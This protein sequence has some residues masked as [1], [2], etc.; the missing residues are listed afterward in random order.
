MIEKL[1]AWS[2]PGDWQRVTTLDVHTEGEPLRIITGGFPALVGKTILQKREFSKKNFDTLR[3]LLM[4]EPRGHA[5]MYGCIVT[6]QV[7][8]DADLGVLFL[9]NEGYSTMCGHGVI[10]LASAL[11]QTGAIAPVEPETKIVMDTPAGKVTAFVRVQGG[12]VAS[13]YFHNVPS[14]VDSLDRTLDVPEFGK[15]HYDIAFGGAYYAYLQADQLGLT[16]ASSEYRKLIEMGMAIKNAVIRSTRIIHPFEEDLGFLYGVI[17]IAPPMSEGVHSR[18]VCVFADGQVDRSPT[19]TGVSGRMA[20]HLARDEVGIGESIVIESIIGS[21]F[22]GRVV[23]ETTF[24]D[25]KAIIPE[26]EGRAFITGKNEFLID[27]GDIF[28]QGFVLS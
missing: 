15:I 16:C 3:S 13:A 12:K 9:H 19:G 7:S 4:A 22:T 27:P 11:V 2:P 10:G 17:F 1:S 24:G 5:D 28:P 20:L 18:N 8:S 21:R 14:F 23:K 26:V 6:P 25:G